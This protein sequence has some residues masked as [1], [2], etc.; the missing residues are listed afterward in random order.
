MKSRPTLLPTCGSTASGCRAPADSPSPRSLN[1]FEAVPTY[2]NYRRRLQ[3]RVIAGADEIARTLWR[4]TAARPG[5][6]RRHPFEATVEAGMAVVSCDGETLAHLPV[7]DAARVGS[8]DGTRWAATST[9]LRLGAGSDLLDPVSQCPEP[10]RLESTATC[11][12]MGARARR[13]TH[14]SQAGQLTLSLQR[15]C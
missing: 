9:H 15:A 2:A 8:P 14:V 3:A 7:E 11:E 4:Q 12:L 10:F 1:V 13:A 5:G 6:L